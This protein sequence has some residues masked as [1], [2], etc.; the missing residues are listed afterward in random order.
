MASQLPG[1]NAEGRSAPTHPLPQRIT[2]SDAAEIL[3]LGGLSGMFANRVTLTLTLWV[4]ARAG[5]T[6]A[7]VVALTGLLVQ[8]VDVEF[9]GGA[10]NSPAEPAGS[11]RI[12]TLMP[13]LPDE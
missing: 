4:P 13:P 5:L 12:S 1:A 9:T 10:L 11:T 3:P 7:T 2:V 8:K 6:D